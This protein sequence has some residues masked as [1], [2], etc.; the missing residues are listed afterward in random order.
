M[1]LLE[2]LLLE[3]PLDHCLDLD[4]H[5]ELDYDL[6]ELESLVVQLLLMMM[7]DP[8]CFAQSGLECLIHV[9][10]LH[11][12]KA[13]EELSLLKMVTPLLVKRQL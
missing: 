7:V 2:L 1:H 9:V 6:E 5:Q 11:P 10:T 12:L 13:I 3:L 4:R 8:C